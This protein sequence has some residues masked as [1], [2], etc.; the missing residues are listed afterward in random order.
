MA[1]SAS[2]I[3]I[4]ASWRVRGFLFPDSK[5][6]SVSLIPA[7][8]G[9]AWQTGRFFTDK[10]FAY[11]D[12]SSLRAAGG[13]LVFYGRVPE[14]QK[15]MSLR[16]GLKDNGENVFWLNLDKY[17]SSFTGS[18]WRKASIPLSE[19]PEIKRCSSIIFQLPEA[20]APGAIM[21]IKDIRFEA[22]KAQATKFNVEYKLLRA[23]KEFP[24]FNSDSSERPAIK[25]S[26]FFYK[27]KPDF[28]IG[29]WTMHEAWD[30]KMFPVH[31][32]HA[33][34]S[35]Y[36][37]LKKAYKG[38]FNKKLFED[39]GF[40]T[41][42]PQTPMEPV[43]EENFPLFIRKSDY[44]R[45]SGHFEYIKSLKD[46]PLIVDFATFGVYG[47]NVC[48]S[49][50]KS[51]ELWQKMTGKKK[52]F[53]IAQV[54]DKAT[55]FVPFCPESQLGS[56][57]YTNLFQR[58][59]Y[60]LLE[61][62]SNPWFYE[63]FNEPR[64]NCQCVFNRALFERFLEKLHQTPEKMNQRYG[65]GGK[66]ASF[67]DASASVFPKHPALWSDWQDF[68]GKQW[69]KVALKYK[70]KILKIDKRK[71][72]F[73]YVQ[74]VISSV[75]QTEALSGIN[76]VEEQK[77]LDAL[78]AE[79]G[80]GFGFK[81]LDVEIDDMNEVMFRDRASFGHQFN[82]DVIKA[83]APEKPMINAECN[84]MRFFKGQR[85]PTRRS[86]VVTSLWTEFFHGSS[87]VI[88][89]AWEKRGPQWNSF[90]KA[91]SLLDRYPASWLNPMAYPPSALL[92][93]K[94]FKKEL[95]GIPSEFYEGKRILGK[96]AILI[97]R[98]TI[99]QYQL[100]NK[101]KD[102]HKKL[103]KSVYGSLMKTH[104]PV[105]FVYEEKGLGD[106]SQFSML[107]VASC[108]YVL[109][110]TKRVI[111]EYVK[112]GGILIRDKASFKFD[113]YGVS[114]NCSSEIDDF[115]G[116]TE[117]GVGKGKV[118][119]ADMES[120]SFMNFV[121]E[122]YNR[123][124]GALSVDVAGADG[125]NPP[126]ELQVI[127]RG[128]QKLLF[129]ANWSPMKTYACLLSFNLADSFYVYDLSEKISYGKCSAER[130]RAGLKTVLA[131]EVRKIILMTN[132]EEEKYRSFKP[133]S[134]SLFEKLKA[135][136]ER[137]L[138]DSLNEASGILKDRAE[139][140]R[141]KNQF[142]DTENKKYFTVDLSKH[143]NRSFSDDVAGD[144][145]GGW[146]D[147]GQN[148][149]SSIKT[150][151][152]RLAGVPFQIIAPENNNGKSCIVLKGAARPYFPEAVK[153]IKID[154]KSAKLFFLHTA[155]WCDDGELLKYVIN[156]SDGKIVFP[157]RTGREIGDWWGKEKPFN[158]VRA[159]QGRNS[160]H[161]PVALY[162]CEW[163]NPCPDK[164][165]ESLDVVSSGSGVPV[166]I[167]VTGEIVSQKNGSSTKNAK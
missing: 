41:A 159:W 110:D 146:T 54:C 162:G 155:G 130:M 140:Y 154:K 105:E 83:S 92:G 43:A 160:V 34:L 50:E 56:E 11:I 121:K 128:S 29:P 1:D 112:N 103:L 8:D 102:G 26:T 70:D 88:L 111:A 19:F 12:L 114:L 115:K 96:A 53:D 33:E 36:P 21:E 82:L 157:I 24:S 13:R 39:L 66:F 73:F 145:K 116:L 4:P 124:F 5:R 51:F 136:A 63:I 46:M 57:I 18:K 118:I 126:A 127:D 74:P 22:D 84:V 77:G 108:E 138:E 167:A 16:L 158:A 106:L 52:S 133:A 27:N 113:R 32:E 75:L 40:S 135:V 107:F 117:F 101:N 80:V 100:K 137:N 42:H 166:L 47:H 90:D 3:T 61:A 25:N 141:T 49:L 149:L 60:D 148:D 98:P 10:P 152:H 150:G 79:G 123:N 55:G 35:R 134:E 95:A 23:C 156:Y 48:K 142:I 144:K 68:I 89:Y 81:S 119:F 139:K 6:E 147:Q 37:F 30:K 38:D 129:L 14:K 99:W 143:A 132:I 109:D 45:Y 67:K 104:I 165:I 125:K 31:T 9:K 87:S 15:G 94:D 2:G 153:N 65:Q 76:L 20:P 69:N 97:S 93:I 161:A 163:I 151:T 17:F 91:E 164:I 72:V 7:N 59:V 131:S 85:M 78:G 122:Q 86:D 58:G 62:G 28:L 64:Y 120:K 71:N 44:K